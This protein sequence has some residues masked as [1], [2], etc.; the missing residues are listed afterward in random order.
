M[1]HDISERNVIPLHQ[2]GGEHGCVL[3]GP[4]AVVA[5]VFAHFDTDG[6]AI[7][8]T[9]E[10]RMFALF[11]RWHVLNGSIIIHGVMPNQKADSVAVFG[12]GRTKCAVLECLRMTFCT[13]REVLRAMNG[14]VARRHGADNFPPVC[15]L[16]DHVHLQPDLTEHRGC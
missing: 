7:S 11:G 8:R 15:S 13:S 10:I 2:D 5:F 3:D 6:L 9:M 12:N 4:G 14:D 1:R 16:A